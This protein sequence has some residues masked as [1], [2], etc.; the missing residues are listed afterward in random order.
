MIWA[1]TS[2]TM[3]HKKSAEILQ[4]VSIIYIMINIS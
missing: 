2:L 4:A 3:E 1:V